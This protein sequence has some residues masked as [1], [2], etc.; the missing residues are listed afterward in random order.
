MLLYTLWRLLY[1]IRFHNNFRCLAISN[2]K[3][4]KNWFT[5]TSENGSN[6]ILFNDSF[7]FLIRLKIV[8]KVFQNAQSWQHQTTLYFTCF[9]PFKVMC[10]AL[11]ISCDLQ[12]KNHILHCTW[13]KITHHRKLTIFTVNFILIC[14][15]SN[16]RW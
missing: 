10:N 6:W 16:L 9:F 3:F 7:I 4:G 11:I 15:L 14:T 1:A 5:F 13:E 12:Q 8:Q 2:V